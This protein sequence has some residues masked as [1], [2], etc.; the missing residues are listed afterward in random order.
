MLDGIDNALLIHNPVAGRHRRRR[1]RDLAAAC[2]LLGEAG[3][4]VEIA[5]TS[6]PGEASTF[7]RKA[8]SD[9]C[10][11]V[12]ACGGDG[13]INEIANGLVGS[14]V[15]LAILPAGTANVLG[16]E[17]DLPWNIPAAARL[18]PTGRLRRI[19]LGLIRSNPPEGTE[20]YFVC[21]AGAGVDGS[22]V[23]RVNA[24]LKDATGTLAYWF[25]GFQHLFTYPLARFSVEA[26]GQ[27]ILSPQVIV[28]RTRHYGGPFQ[29]TPGADLFSDR[30]ELAIFTFRNRFRF[31]VHLVSNWS[32]RLRRP[33]DVHFI[34]ATRLTCQPEPG[35]TVYVEIDGEPAGKLPVE[36]EVVP[37]AL[38]LVVPASMAEPAQAA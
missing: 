6:R 31:P 12:I 18:I 5:D 7:A 1:A 38:T 29:I 30:F 22:M 17:L 35:S 9:S 24:R 11:M 4:R 34:K 13:T 33:G 15:P 27:C 14:K 28:G 32:T 37:D 2:R 19:A 25:S 36:F 3:I 26:D 16:N 8:A 20:R 21:V 23:H 10:G